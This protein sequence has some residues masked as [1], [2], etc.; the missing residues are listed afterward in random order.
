MQKNKEMNEVARIGNT[1]AKIYYYMA[2]EILDSF[3]KEGEKV[4]R[5]GL[6]KAGTSDGE[7]IRNITLERGDDLNLNSFKKSM[8]VIWPEGST[9]GVAK[10]RT[11]KGSLFEITGCAYKDLWAT[12]PEGQ[13]TGAIF[14]EEYHPT[15]W[16]GFHEKLRLQ[17]EKM[18]TKGDSC[19][20]F[21]QYF[22]E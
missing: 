2:K 9:E 6:R 22:I 13:K 3:G 16:S 20:S 5:A 21:K 7:L 18:L 19:C 4:L 15:M 14:C 10:Y 12:L 8:D 17:L 11:E 1:W